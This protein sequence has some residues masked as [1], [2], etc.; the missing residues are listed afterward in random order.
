MTNK[1]PMGIVYGMSAEAYFADPGVSN[2]MLSAM[3]KSPAHCWALYID[4][5]R[6]EREATDAMSAGTLAHC[7]ILEPDELAT[8][9]V[10][11][12]DGMSFASKD[13]K[14]WRDAQPA[15]VAIIDQDAY[16]T[17]QRQRDAV[18]RIGELRRLLSSGV[19]EVSLFWVDAETGLRCKARVD[20]LHTIAPRHV[21]PLDLKTISDLT[22]DAVSRA[23]TNYGYHRQRAHYLNGLR[24]CGLRA[25]DFGFAFVSSSYPFLAAPYIVDDETAD[26]GHEEVAE[27][28][29]RFANCQK[30]NDWP[31]FGDGFQLT[32]LMKWARRT[33]EVEVSYVD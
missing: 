5:E 19:S 2:S 32:G 22:P 18:M 9:Y 26:Q 6:P 16:I 14:A 33:Q 29:D 20:W 21:M 25:D 1:L 3:A 11:K 13:G 27:L 17:A 24:A 15:G 4:P 10:V 28:L 7:A 23:V 8:R 31:A 30:S 12:P